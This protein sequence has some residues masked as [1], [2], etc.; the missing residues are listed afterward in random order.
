MNSEHG[1]AACGSSSALALSLV[2]LALSACGQDPAQVAPS[3]VEARASQADRESAAWLGRSFDDWK[4]ACDRLPANRA[5]NRSLKLHLPSKQLSPLKTFQDFS[6]VLEAFFQQA[7]N[8]PLGNPDTWLGRTPVHE[9]FFNTQS[10]YFTSPP[11][12]FEPF[13]QRVLLAPGSQVIIRGDLHGDIHSLIAWIEWL[14]QHDYMDGFKIVRPDV[15]ILFLGDYTNRGMYG[16]EVLYT[17]L[18]LKLANPER[19]LLARGNHED[20]NLAGRYG[21]IAE[22]RAKYAGEFDASRVLRLYDFL[23]VALY[24]C[25]GND[26]VQFIHGGLE[27]GFNP[28][29]LL[30]APDTV[31]FQ[32]LGPLHQAKFLRDNPSYRKILSKREQSLAA[33]SLL[34]FNPSSPT[35]PSLIGFM[36]N[37]FTL[38]RGEPEFQYDPAR[39]FVYGERTVKFLLDR[40]NGTNRTVRAIFRAHQHSSLIN[41]MMRRLIASGGVYRHWQEN[42][43]VELLD[44]DLQRLAAQLDTTEVRGIPPGSVWT[45]NVSP[46]SI[47]GEGCDFS[48]D[49]F[50]ILVVAGPFDRWQLR[51]IS[52][53]PGK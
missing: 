42:D 6:E 5:L 19:V 50:G 32:L 35:V 41:P 38:V 40:L 39:A 10:S 43:S 44:A 7:R 13:V 22:G 18:R 48:C 33:G 30:D 31:Q 21:L 53:S 51:V 29:P 49:S 47:Y 37:D 4:H 17:I 28:G 15:Y 3:L 8:S 34:D 23:P 16:M 26:A 36:W 46:D 11:L 1:K 2:L 45:F 9:Q 24:L 27:P 12:P 20:A 52:Y 14:N 25:G